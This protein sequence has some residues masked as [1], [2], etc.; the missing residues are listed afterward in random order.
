MN[1]AE[2][3]RWYL[4]NF[5]HVHKLPVLSL[6]IKQ[7]TLT[8]QFPKPEFKIYYDADKNTC[9]MTEPLSISPEATDIEVA[10]AIL[11]VCFDYAWGV[12][13]RTNP[14]PEKEWSVEDIMRREG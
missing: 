1:K 13:V 7:N 9:R 5:A 10:Y 11:Q 4:L 12:F 2:R 8:V 6:E 3:V 14:D